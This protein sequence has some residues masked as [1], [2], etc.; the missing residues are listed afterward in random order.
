MP[1]FDQHTQ[2]SGNAATRALSVTHVGTEFV[3]KVYQKYYSDI[4]NA[5]VPVDAGNFQRFGASTTPTIVL[6]DRHGVV[7]LYN[8][9]A[10]D[11]VSLR[12]AIERLIVSG[13][14]QGD[15]EAA[16]R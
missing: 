13:R 8:P 5:G 3:E 12:A 11:E 2:R 1:I 6:V 7:R 4:P 9:G 10:M 15:A 14:A 16:K